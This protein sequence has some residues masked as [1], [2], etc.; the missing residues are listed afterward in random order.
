MTIFFSV[1]AGPLCVVIEY[2]F[3]I[4]SR[5]YEGSSSRGLLGEDSYSMVLRTASTQA[6][7]TLRMT[8]PFLV[9]ASKAWQSAFGLPLEG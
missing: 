8:K 1:I 9:I 5:F 3:V 2:S 4:L 6:V 7:A